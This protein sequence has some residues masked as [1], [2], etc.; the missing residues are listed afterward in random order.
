MLIASLQNKKISLCC[1]ICA[2]K[3]HLEP[4]AA[5]I[6][7]LGSGWIQADLRIWLSSQF[8]I[9]LYFSMERKINPNCRHGVRRKGKK[10][11]L[12]LQLSLASYLAK[13]STASTMFVPSLALVSQNRAPYAC[14]AKNGDGEDSAVHLESLSLTLRSWGRKSQRTLA[15]FSPCRVLT[16]LPAGRCS[17]RSTLF[18][19]THIGTWSSV[20]SCRER[21]EA[22]PASSWPVG[23]SPPVGYLDLI[24]PRSDAE[25]A[26]LWSNVVEEQHSVSFTEVGPG[27]AAKP[28]E[29]KTN[30]RS[31]P[32]PACLAAAF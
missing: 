19:T 21:E 15:S 32:S 1:V 23:S 7:L 12:K 8:D 10:K 22:E 4:T 16:Q 30:N 27:N 11:R 31:F 2:D 24:H 18:P 5:V 6:G 3:S 29:K 20:D 14:E 13:W 17:R 26:V 9:L 28:I 25:K